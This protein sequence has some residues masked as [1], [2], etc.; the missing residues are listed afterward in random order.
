MAVLIEGTAIKL[1]GG[2]EFVLP[3]LSVRTMRKFTRD[4]RL[5]LVLSIAEAKGVPTDEQ[6]GAL[7]ELL[8]EGL[9]DN[10][11]TL[12]TDDVEALID[13]SNLG[14]VLDALF[15]RSGFRRTVPGEAV[16]PSTGMN[17]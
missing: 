3:P 11:E 9:R 2:R 15:M 13:V 5:A 10:Y 16:S 4:G 12:T 17:S 1:R 14:M 7:V 8:T 6:W